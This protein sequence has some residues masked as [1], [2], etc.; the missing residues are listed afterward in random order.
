VLKHLGDI[1]I[2]IGIGVEAEGEYQAIE[3]P[4]YPVG[5]HFLEEG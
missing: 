4:K 2:L 3:V 5:G 1:Q